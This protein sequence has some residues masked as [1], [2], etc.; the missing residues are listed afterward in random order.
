MRKKR[1]LLSLGVVVIVIAILYGC[2]FFFHL[3]PRLG[4]DL[5]GGISVVLEAKG[6][7]K[8][9][10]GVLDK[11]VEKIRDRVDSL[12]VSEPEI[13]RQGSR[14]VVVQLPGITDEERALALIGKTAQLQFR[15]VKDTKEEG[16][17]DAPEETPEQD[18]KP[19][20]E[21][22]LPLKEKD[23]TYMLTLEPTAM[24]GDVIKKAQVGYGEE[25]GAQINFE[26][27]GEGK[28]QF[29]ELTQAN[30]DKQLAIVL[31]YE[32]ESAPNIKEPITE[33]KGEITGDFTDKEA[34]DVAI[35]LNTGAL[36]ITLE[37]ITK[38]KVSATLGKDSLNKGLLAGVAGLAIVALFML[39]YYRALGL[40][41]CIGLAIFGLLMYGFIAVFGE[42]WTLTLA[43]VTGIIVAIGIQADSSIVYFERL[44]EEVRSGRTLRSSA[45]RAFK[46]AFR[47]IIAA[48]LVMFLIAAILYLF[49]VGAV[50]GFAFTLGMATLFD[51]FIS[52]FYTRAAVSLLSLWQRFGTPRFMGIRKIP[53]GAVEAE[54]R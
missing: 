48:D 20:A 1:N 3:S 34:K 10:P 13:T 29:A 23:K 41:T 9:D 51:V 27:T 12:G 15:I 17:E 19:E 7:E 53:E 38:T 8:V 28:T 18:L 22:V 43:G 11:T 14:N 37:A 36:P 44:K 6:K 26:L 49:A 42:F 5:R 33:G 50:K 25:G 4:L 52:Y 32:I 47:T 31:D 24:T 46:S 21:V 35:V 45:D 39:I 40:V 30:V 2:V 16:A 54:T